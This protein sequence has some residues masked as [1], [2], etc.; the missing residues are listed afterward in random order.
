MVDTGE[1][2]ARGRV[3]RHNRVARRTFLRVASFTAGVGLLAG[4]VG[5]TAEETVEQ[6]LETAVYTGPG[7]LNRR[8]F[9]VYREPEQ[10]ERTI[11][12][13]RVSWRHRIVVPPRADGEEPTYADLYAAERYPPGSVL[14]LVDRLSACPQEEGTLIFLRRVATPDE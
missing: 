7:R 11:C 3:D 10:D 8:P 13:A 14:E 9:V 5:G 2:D 4:H 6:P 1:G 12:T